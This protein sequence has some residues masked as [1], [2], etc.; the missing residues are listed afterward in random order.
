MGCCEFECKHVNKNGCCDRKPVHDFCTWRSC[1]LDS[2]CKE[3]R[4]N[5]N[6]DLQGERK[7]AGYT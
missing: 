1:N 2:D 7:D 3:C 6:C 5:L 4:K